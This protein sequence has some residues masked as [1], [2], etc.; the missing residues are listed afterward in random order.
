MR[1]RSTA[2][3][4]ALL[5]V[6]CAGYWAWTH[7]ERETA[8]Q[9]AE[10]KRMVDFDA[11]A[12]V[13]MEVRRAEQEP[14]QAARDAS[15]RWT[16]SKPS[17]EIAADIRR[18]ESMA[19]AVAGMV[20]E[21]TI[22]GAADLATYGL[23]APA[24]VVAADAADGRGIRIAFGNMEPIQVNRYARVDDG[25]VVLVS[26]K[27]FQRLDRSLTDLRDRRVFHF[28][29]DEI[30]RIEFARI[31]N[32]RGEAPAGGPVELGTELG[33]VAAERG[34]AS[35]PW[36]VVEPVEAPADQ[37]RIALMLETLPNAMGKS[38]IDKPESLL[39]YGL[40]PAWA[41]LT[42]TAGE[43]LP[44]E[45]L[46]VGSADLEG[47]YDNAVFVKKDNQTQVFTIEPQ[48]MN[49]LPLT[50]T[51][52]RDARLITRPLKGLSGLHYVS[53]DG[54]FILEKSSGQGW[55]MT[56]PPVEQTDQV[57]V[58]TLIGNLVQLT[59]LDFPSCGVEDAGLDQPSVVITLG[60]EQQAPVELRFAPG[61]EG[62]NACFATQDTG[63]I[64]LLPGDTPTMLSRRAADF[65]TFELL[66]FNRGEA[67]QLKLSFEGSNY[68]LENRGG[69]WQV[70]S[71][72]QLM[73]QNQDD[74][75]MILGA[76]SPLTAEETLP[77]EA[78][79]L[80]APYGL[81]TPVF[82]VT[83]TTLTAETP[84]EPVVHGPL[85]IGG[86]VEG[87]PQR[88]YAMVMGRSGVYV[89]RHS[90]LDQLREGLRGV[91]PKATP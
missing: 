10:A 66:R 72:E 16:I 70:T 21:R 24:L 31:W 44:P 55:R 6:L 91:Q 30:R 69:V 75:R 84:N 3:L 45:T 1:I 23:T 59:A 39:D 5:A 60:F 86:P 29:P 58:S 73:L 7:F 79:A 78:G 32:G 81:D 65:E 49:V 54:E 47:A 42:L 40:E 33:R 89:I 83:V 25:P 26:N 9:V 90:V 87:Q 14:V 61:P 19:E 15:G 52:L 22:S 67:V 85:F 76:L 12:I 50:R 20:N 13:R 37:E 64:M 62:A 18:W 74:A 56:M 8:R 41:R 77:L 28:A 34:S 11:R 36:R 63:A 48:L 71:P 4:A 88:R 46:W 53:Q 82:S 35:E 51:H 17:P 27:T 38:Y 68:T 80:V 57:A 43:G 2:I